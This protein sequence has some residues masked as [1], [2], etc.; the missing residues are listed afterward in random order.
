MI[1]CPWW[2]NN[3]VA[4][5]TTRTWD[6]VG[7]YG[8]SIASCTYNN[9]VCPTYSVSWSF[10]ANGSGATVRV[11]GVDVTANASGNFSRSGISSGTACNDI[12]ATRAG[13]SCTTTSNRP[14]SITSN[15]T[16]LGGTCSNPLASCTAA[17]QTYNATT[18]YP[19]CDTADKIVC[20]GNNAWFIWA[21][22]N[23]GS[24]IAGTTSS[25]Y[26]SMFE[27]WRNVSFPSSWTVSTTAG[28]LSLAAANAT[29]NHI[30]N[31]TAPYDWLTPKDDNRWWGSGTTDTVGTY[32]TVSTANQVL[33]KWPCATNYHVPTYKEANDTIAIWLWTNI[34]TFNTVLKPPLS[35]VRTWSDGSLVYQGTNGY[36]WLSS[37]VNGDGRIVYWHSTG[38][39]PTNYTGRAQG[40]AV[41][42]VR[43]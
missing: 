35:G 25:S 40:F 11:C 29:S 31:S 24:T 37:T 34:T 16:G 41:R 19:W 38:V 15:T 3:Q 18:T 36:W 14:A 17:R 22:C 7:R 10:A 26:G 1:L 9:P 6:C 30:T 39:G 33:M 13:Y 21:M 27:W 32:S 20:T 43:N 5:G 42:C 4:C 2:S 12:A 28:P 8:G 23:I